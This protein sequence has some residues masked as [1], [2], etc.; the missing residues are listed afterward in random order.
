[1]NV[2][3]VGV[4]VAKPS[5]ALALAKGGIRGILIT[6]PFASQA[7]LNLLP[8]IWALDPQLIVYTSYLRCHSHFIYTFVLIPLCCCC[9]YS[10]IDSPTMAR[11]LSSVLRTIPYPSDGSEPKQLNVLLDIDGGHHRTGCK[12][13]DALDLALFIQ[14]SPGLRLRGVQ[15]Y[16]GHIQVTAPFNMSSISDV[17]QQSL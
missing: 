2:G 11:T 4:C 7:S 17:Y 1:M 12:P 9:Y 3:A 16:I 14:S 15:C 10:A 8:Q 13:E 5:E 6:S